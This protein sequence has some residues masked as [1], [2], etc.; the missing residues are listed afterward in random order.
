MAFTAKD[1]MKRASSILQDDGAVRWPATEL[2]DYLNDGL[3]ELASMK[4]NA[5]T[6][7]TSLTLVAGAKQ[8]LPAAYTI[9][10]RVIRNDNA[11]G[12]GAKK[13]I[14]T[15][16]KRE[17]MDSQIPNWQDTS[18]LPA[19]LNVTHVIHDIVDPRTFYVVPSNLGA[20]KIEV[21]VG[22]LPATIPFPTG[23]LMLDLDNY[24]TDV[25]VSDVYR[26]ALVDY[27]VYR[28]FSKDSGI[29]A[30]AQRAQAHYELFKAGIGYFAASEAAIS[31]ATQNAK[32]SG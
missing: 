1:V 18:V 11:T 13:S 2:C 25:D 4:P 29:P 15:L 7:T 23:A 14:S 19:S 21:V 32:T 10:S 22:S 27:V 8:T 5:K 31:V 17:V 24:T 6:V 30:A 16:T 3:R 20:G 26:N 9:L 12:T 28:A